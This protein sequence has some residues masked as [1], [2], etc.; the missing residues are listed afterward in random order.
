MAPLSGA[1]TRAS[2]ARGAR[3]GCCAT[4]PTL[5]LLAAATLLVTYSQSILE[6][7]FAIWALHRYGFGPRTVGFL[8]FAIA[9]PALLMQGGVVRL[10]APRVGEARLAS[11]GVLLYVAGLV[12]LGCA[13]TLGA[14]VIGL[15]L[16]GIGLGAYNPSASALASRQSASTTAGRCSAR[17]SP[18]PVLRV[19]SGPFTSGP[20]Y[21]GLGPVGAVPDRRVRDAA[22]GVAGAPGA[23]RAHL[24][25]RCLKR[26]GRGAGPAPPRSVPSTT[27]SACVGSGVRPAARARARRG[28]RTTRRAAGRPGVWRAAAPRTAARAHA[29]RCCRARTGPRGCGT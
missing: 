10:L 17:T 22:R 14:T 15:L 1:R 5:A 4:R 16:C 8:L 21:A 24:R 25:L 6:S 18:A 9:L 13:A 27:R 12:T 29:C 2:P 26:G 19:S 20:L 11:G 7:I 28:C 3:G 23:P